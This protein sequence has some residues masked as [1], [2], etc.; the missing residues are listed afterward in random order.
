[1][2]KDDKTETTTAVKDQNDDNGKPAPKAF[3]TIELDVSDVSACYSNFC[4]VSSTPEEVIID[5]GLNPNPFAKGD[6]TIPASNRIVLNHF[7]AK[8]LMGA[9][10]AAVKQH[11]D[12]FGVL[13][14]DVRKRFQPT[15]R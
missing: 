10:S 2:A 13:E 4:R 1:M 3:G 8:R 14:V 11:E 12:A 9:L 6:V 5:M 15:G 7:T